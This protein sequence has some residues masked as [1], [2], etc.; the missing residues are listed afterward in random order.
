M[1]LEAL[2]AEL[3]PRTIVLK[4]D[5]P[6]RELEGLKRCVS[7]A[8]GDGPAPSSRLIENDAISWADCRSAEDR[9]VLRPARQ[10]ALRRDHRGRA[11]SMSLQPG[12]AAASVL[13]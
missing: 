1:L 12:S 2:E 9:L 11:R 10:P 3:P 4:N 8:K 6:V 13:R 7:V 5:L